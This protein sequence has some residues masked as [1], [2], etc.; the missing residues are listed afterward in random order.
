VAFVQYDIC[1]ARAAAM[2]VLALMATMDDTVN[3]AA[4][5][6]HPDSIH[7]RRSGQHMGVIEEE[8]ARAAMP[9][10]LHS[11]VVSAS[12]YSSNGMSDGAHGPAMM[13]RA[14]EAQEK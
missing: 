12:A 8:A 11:A 6:A 9:T 5:H 10:T 4:S 14:W 2:S 13:R 1:P 7:R 3:V